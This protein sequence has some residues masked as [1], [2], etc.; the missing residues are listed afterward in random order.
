ML[1]LNLP[2]FDFRLKKEKNGLQIFD[3]YRKKYVKLTPEEWVRQNFLNFLI[4]EKAYP[5]GLVAVEKELKINDMRKRCDAII[6]D[7]HAKPLV[8]I[9][10]KAPHVP[11]TQDVFD[12]VAVYNSKL[13][14]D[15][16]MISN[17]ME[18]HCCRVDNS[19]TTYHFFQEIPKFSELF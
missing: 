6:Y 17:G 8:I 19:K 7:S 3:I 4:G 15:F 14:V 18:H 16:F 10:L 12:Q 13:K 11:I 9:E 5:L 2:K 1:E